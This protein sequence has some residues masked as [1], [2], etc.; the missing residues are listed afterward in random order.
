MVDW[1]GH[2]WNECNIC[3]NPDARRKG[4]RLTEAD[5]PRPPLLPGLIVG[6]A[7]LIVLGVQPLLYGAYVHQGLI[8][9]ARLGSLAAAEISA[10]AFGSVGGI[11][12][13]RRWPARIVGLLGLVLLVFGNLAP[14]ALTLFIT[15]IVA[16]AGGGALVS[17]AATQIAGRDNVNAA[18]GA[19]L[20]LQATSQYAVLQ[21]FSLF[22]PAASAMAVQQALAGMAAAAGLLLLLVPHTLRPHQEECGS[23]LPPGGGWVAL[24][25]SALFVGGAVGT[26]AYFGVWLE[27]AG[28]AGDGV[29]ARL[30]ASMAGQ[31]IGAVIA[32]ALGTRRHSSR[33]V[34]AAGLFLIAALV[35]LLLRGPDGVAG[36]AL[37]AGFGVAWMIGTPALSGLLLELDPTR[38][39]LPYAASAQ[40]LGAA[41][42]PTLTGELLAAHGLDLV[43][44]C[45]AV[46][47][48][49]AITTVLGGMALRQTRHHRTLT[50]PIH[51]G[52][53]AESQ[54]G[55]NGTA[56]A[57]GNR[58]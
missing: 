30:T 39:S 23:G 35:L 50:P 32:I 45:S 53:S 19:Y 5:K 33:Q 55:S 43:L 14:F 25:A 16:G 22:A 28:L 10:I 24:A 27:A 3:R 31:M 15:R 4:I 49:A 9:E 52:P 48:A 57:P 17:I 6:T 58:R 47:F 36:W 20:L 38:R 1:W 11:A 40:L 37:I 13:L 44:A 54:V 41:V 8:D 34:M 12:L 42:V 2:R 7:G 51:S 46:L 21:G 56:P 18:S 26:W 29:A